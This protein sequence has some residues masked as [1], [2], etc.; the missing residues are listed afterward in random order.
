[1]HYTKKLNIP[2]L[3][4]DFQ[5]AFDSLEWDFLEAALTKF[6]FGPSLIQWVQTL[7]RGASSCIINNG[8]TSGYFSLNRGVRQGDPLSPYLFVIAVELLA[9]KIRQ[10]IDIKGV[11]IKNVEAK[12][13]QYAD[14]TSGIL[15]DVHSAKIFLDITEEFGKFSGLVLNRDKTEAMW[16]GASS[17]NTSKPL[18]V[19]WPAEPLRVLGVHFS[20]NEK[21]CNKANFENK[22]NKCEQIINLWNMRNLTMLGRVQIIKTFLISQFLFVSSCIEMPHYV[23][24][25]ITE[26]VFKFI[27]KNGRDKIKRAALYKSIEN[28]GLR[29]PDIQEMINASKIMWLRKYMSDQSHL[30]KDMFRNHLKSINLDPKI[31]LHANFDNLD[32]KVHEAHSI[33]P[34]FYIST[35]KLWKEVITTPMS[36]TQ[37]IWLNKN[38]KIGGQSVFYRKLH[39]A[40]MYYVSDL[41]DNEGKLFPFVYWKD[42]GLRSVDYMKWA[43][44]VS[45]VKRPVTDE[46]NMSME[47]HCEPDYS[48]ICVYGQS[49]QKMNSSG[50]EDLMR[51]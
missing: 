48:L 45:S 32:A 12:L 51:S 17:D 6:N 16:I 1:M 14:D 43:G 22:I 31:F 33:L 15:R 7:Y 39:D 23:K 8:W 4:I 35:L 38:I 46:T 10:N 49:V 27:W 2:G 24:R 40:G 28:G 34:E 36:K 50:R 5:K 47:K 19:S 37:Y 30:W 42:R 11:Q 9:C 18:G 20:Y 25:R 13:L 26:M 44:I 29:V 41:F 3:L 21:E